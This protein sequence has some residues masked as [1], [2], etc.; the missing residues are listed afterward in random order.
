MNERG[1]RS[2]SSSEARN[3]RR[4][5][6]VVVAWLAC[7]SMFLASHSAAD[8]EDLEARLRRP[9]GLVLSP[10][11]ST[12][13]V[14]N[15]R[16]GTVST[17]D[18]G[19]RS[20]TSEA[21]VGRRLQDLAATADRRLLLTVDDAAH[22]LIL[23][24][25]A[26]GGAPPQV[27]QRLAVSPYPVGVIARRD[28]VRAYVTSLWSRRLTIVDLP[29]E[30]GQAARIARVIELDIAPRKLTLVQNERYLIVADAFGG[31]L[32]VFDTNDDTLVGLREFPGHNVRGLGLNADSRMLVVSHQ[33]LNDLAHTIRNDVHWGLL[34]S[35]DLRWLKLDR[36]IQG[37]GELFQGGHMHPLG[38]AGS[39]TGDP[40]GL[41]MA[42]DGTV[43][44]TLAGVDEVSIGREADFSLHRTPVGRRPTA[45][46]ITSDSKTALVANTFGDSIS[47]VDL[48][49]RE[50][51]AEISLGPQPTLTSVDRGELL[52]YDARLSHDGWMS[53]N[54]CHSD[55]HTNGQLND[56]FS[57]ASF[58]APKRV[59]TLLGAADTGPFA[60]N[61]SAPMLA[62]QIRKSLTV[63]MQT[64]RTV[65]DGMLGDL[66]AYVESLR[67]PPSVALLRGVQD[68]AAVGRGR[69]LFQEQRCQRCHTAPTYTSPKTYN[70]GLK[71][72]EGNDHFNPPSLRGVGQRAPY[73][74]DNRAAS[75]DEV[76]GKFKHQ[77][78]RELS[79][80]E[81][82]D[83]KAFLASL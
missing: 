44:V 48:E 42:P 70:V 18:I 10:D 75:L 6:L 65:S 22:E 21:A 20:V 77:L 64:N 69:E 9:I 31:K 13:W 27:K 67:S 53:C 61:A 3:F 12:L 15:Q 37:G 60:W 49:E 72:K 52:F 1:K 46:V 45:V 32:A 83:M 43:V 14:A 68:D 34:M 80:A 82:A 73:F 36:V 62:D 41:A 50:S 30:P 47:I 56:N 17:L 11:N 19:R 79:D 38:H 40:A 58:G 81:R 29:R 63:T 76:L 71:D 2:C 23:L 39:A 4:G 33:M 54:S 66:S 26:A 5:W 16:T 74:H 59:L 25:P 28:G 57:D 51:K 8:A 7:G 55:G 24:E 35:N 78:K